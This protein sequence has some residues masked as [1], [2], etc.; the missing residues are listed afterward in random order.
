MHV[1]QS[2]SILID[3]VPSEAQVVLSSNKLL[4]SEQDPTHVLSERRLLKSTRTR[5]PPPTGRSPYKT[6][7][8]SSPR[9]QSSA[10][11]PNRYAEKTPEP[12]LLKSAVKRKL[13]FHPD[14]PRPSIEFSPGKELM[15]GPLYASRDRTQPRTD[16]LEFQPS[17]SIGSKRRRDPE[18]V[19]IPEEEEE[20]YLNGFDDHEEMAMYDKDDDEMIDGDF[21]VQIDP[22]SPVSSPIKKP[23]KKGRKSNGDQSVIDPVLLGRNQPASNFNV[24][25]GAE[26]DSHKEA[27]ESRAVNGKKKRLPNGTRQTKRKNAND[28]SILIEDESVILAP[29]VNDSSLIASKRGRGKPKGSKVEVHQDVGNDDSEPQPPSKKAKTAAS[30]PKERDVNVMMPPPLRPTKTP[31]V[32]PA[33]RRSATLSPSKRAGAAR[34]LTILREGTPAADPGARRTRS[35]RQ[36]IK[37]L[38]YWLGERGEHDPDGTLVGIVRAESVDI[39]PRRQAR[40]PKPAAATRGR[41]TR[42]E[43]TLGVIREGV[44]GYGEYDGVELEEWEEEGGVIRG[45]VRTWDAALNAA[46]QSDMREQDL[47]FSSTSI[48][49][50]DVVGS[51]FKYAKFLSLPFFGCGMVDIPPGGFKR[52]KNSRKMQMV[53]FL[54]RGKVLVRV[55]EAE[56]CISKGG[57]WHV[58]R[59]EFEFFCIP[60][61]LPPRSLHGSTISCQIQ[62]PRRLKIMMPLSTAEKL[63][64]RCTTGWRTLRQELGTLEQSVRELTRYP[65]YTWW[66]STL[67][68]KVEGDL[69][70]PDVSICSNWPIAKR[71]RTASSLHH[72]FH[73]EGYLRL[74]ASSHSR[75]RLCNRKLGGAVQPA[76]EV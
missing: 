66:T 9:R 59:G 72:L 25:L 44:E 74:P 43:S 15:K 65:T 29:A 14:K 12:A 69:V 2:E 76:G 31:S 54:H 21:T 45:F 6:N 32:E 5:L 68:N 40:R 26:R 11:P 37:P 60:F 23:N 38:E 58:P 57:V 42:D 67:A 19:E 75:Q 24:S 52:A 48:E 49:T 36:V 61:L 10:A 1:A 13:D 17:P 7:I 41:K 8:G 51:D 30:A 63:L 33:N 16:E 18:P 28:S 70:L 34:S 47:A 46:D 64:A 27:T 20:P 53:F 73:L 55:G 71:A 22:E 56:F 4:G 62:C 35:G 3:R 39:A 50:R